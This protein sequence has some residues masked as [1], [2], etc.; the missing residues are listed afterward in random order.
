MNV[1]GPKEVCPTPASQPFM[2]SHMLKTLQ[3]SFP[4]ARVTASGTAGGARL[5]RGRDRAVALKFD[6]LA[7]TLLHR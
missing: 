4:A 1:F 2:L 7:R 6:P 5:R 3:V